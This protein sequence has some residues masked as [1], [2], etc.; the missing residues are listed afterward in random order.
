M[1]TR[2]TNAKRPVSINTIAPEDSGLFG[3]DANHHH[4]DWN[5]LADH[6]V[7]ELARWVARGGG[8]LSMGGTSDGAGI[9][10][11]IRYGDSSKGFTF[12]TP[13]QFD[14]WARRVTDAWKLRSAPAASPNGKKP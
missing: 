2:R 5:G 14:Q 8:L 10:V 3:V 6:T 9:Y 13:D 4:F 12:D 11:S 7:A 1:T